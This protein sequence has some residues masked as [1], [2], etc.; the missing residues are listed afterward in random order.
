MRPSIAHLHGC[1]TTEIRR[2]AVAGNQGQHVCSA[3]G[4][5][6]QNMYSKAAVLKQES[7]LSTKVSKEVGGRPLEST[8]NSTQRGGDCGTAGAVVVWD[9]SLSFGSVS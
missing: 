1:L 3:R 8:S 2:W 9:T 6:E 7:Q 5:T 4:R